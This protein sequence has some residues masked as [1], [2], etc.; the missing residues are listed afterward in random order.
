[1]NESKEAITRLSYATTFVGLLVF[2]TLATEVF[3]GYL[4]VRGYSLSD[5]EALLAGLVIWTS[6]S[7]LGQRFIKLR[8]SGK[9]ILLISASASAAYYRFFNMQRIL[10][11]EVVFDLIGYALV[12][13]MFGS[14]AWWELINS[15]AK[16]LSKRKMPKRTVFIVLVTSSATFFCIW[17]GY[18]Y[19]QTIMSFL[20]NHPWAVGLIGIIVSIAM[21]VF[22]GRRTKD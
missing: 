5:I 2:S 11:L 6:F 20:D 10:S 18:S 1:M 16:N 12:A 13:A 8:H 21:G 7:V 19:Q 15:V 14:I 4:L 9:W 22:I 17:A 3:L